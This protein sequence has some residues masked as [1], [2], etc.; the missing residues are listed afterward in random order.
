MKKLRQELKYFQ[1]FPGLSRTGGKPALLDVEIQKNRLFHIFTE[2][3]QF[4]LNLNNC[5]NKIIRLKTMS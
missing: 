1:D 4:Q 2:K 5:G 3:S